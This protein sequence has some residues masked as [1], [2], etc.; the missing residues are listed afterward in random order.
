MENT[1]PDY[2]EDVAHKAPLTS[3]TEAEKETPLMKY[4]FG[5]EVISIPLDDDSLDEIIIQRYLPYILTKHVINSADCQHFEDVYKGK[6]HIFSKAREINPDKK[7]SIINENHAF[8]MVEFKKG[9]MFGNPIKY[10]SVDD[11]ISTDDMTYLN[12][13]MRDQKKAAKDIENGETVFKCGNS[14]RMIL[15]K[16]YGKV[17][18]IMKESPFEIINLD[19]KTTFVVY[20]SNFKKKKLFGG[21]ITTIDSPD[22]KEVRYEILIY[23]RKDTYRFRCL[24]LTPVWA[25]IDF[26]NKSSH[27]LEYIPIVEYYTNTAR[28]G[29]IEIVETIL[30]SINYISSDSVDNI[31]DFVNSILAVYNM[32][33]DEETKKSI[34]EYKSLELKTTDP[35]RPADAKYLV[36]ALNQSDVMIKYEALVK[37]AYNIVGVPIPT[38]KASSGGDTG[39]ARELGGGWENAN[40]IAKQNEEPLKQG[41]CMML[42]I[43]LSI[44]K[45]IP[46]CPVNELYVSDI[47]INFNR[48]IRHNLMTKTQSLE[49]LDRLGFP[50]ETSLNIVELTTNPHEVAIEWEKNVKEKENN[51]INDNKSIKDGGGD[52]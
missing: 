18:N 21:I 47:D 15:P 51:E 17:K 24:S 48:T 5:R 7:N 1:I 29:V 30:D 35:S 41:E 2:E 39:D 12:S 28:L 37:V 32:I 20:S 27:F 4:R 44:C 40:I 13:Y 9:Y 38:T 36:N 23:T 49:T 50:K 8:S 26:I 11:S 6:T 31:D 10:S 52:M 22:P 45:K 42:E 46:K 16:K 34:Q 43:V 19:N 33:V 3:G 14:F 25:G